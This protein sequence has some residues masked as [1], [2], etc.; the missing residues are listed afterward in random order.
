M[1]KMDQPR[2]TTFNCHQK[3]IQ[4][5]VQTNTLVFCSA[6]LF[7]NFTTITLKRWELATIRTRYHTRLVFPLGACHYQITLS[8]HD[9]S[10][11]WELAT[12][13]TRYPCTISVSVGSLP[14]SEHVIHARLVFPL[15]ACHYQNT[16]SIHDQSFRIPDNTNLHK[17]Q[18]NS[19]IYSHGRLK[20]KYI[21]VFFRDA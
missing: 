14:L 8:I 18:H 19:S 5:W 11:R 17:Q 4:S 10:F 1:G 16:L 9:Q 6:Y 12:I 2:T 20:L 7:Q 15:G 13:R 21:Q 3:S